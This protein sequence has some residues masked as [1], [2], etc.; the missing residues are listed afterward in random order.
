MALYPKPCMSV[1]LPHLFIWLSPEGTDFLMYPDVLVWRFWGTL[2][3]GFSG[4]Q[5]LPPGSGDSRPL[6]QAYAGAQCLV[7]FVDGGLPAPAALSKPAGPFL[8]TR[9]A[10]LFLPSPQC[11]VS[12][13]GAQLDL[14]LTC[15]Q[16]P[17]SSFLSFRAPLRAGVQ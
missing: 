6:I 12:R 1:L 7:P 16:K 11:C 2:L 13:P 17:L 14:K 4:P 9:R 5:L 10:A 8:H 3:S 15:D